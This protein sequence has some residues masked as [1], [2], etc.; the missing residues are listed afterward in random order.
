[1]PPPLLDELLLPPSSPWHLPSSAGPSLG[2]FDGLRPRFLGTFL[3][4]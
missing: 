1:M 3:H 2:T 4:I